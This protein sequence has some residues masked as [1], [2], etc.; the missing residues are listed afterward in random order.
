M[1][2]TKLHRAVWPSGKVFDSGV[3]ARVLG[4]LLV[5]LKIVYTWLLSPV[6]HLSG[7]NI[8]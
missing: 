1:H 3:K 2:H 5:E 6:L 8:G 4:Q 7:K